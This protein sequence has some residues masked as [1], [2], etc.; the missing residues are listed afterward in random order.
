[1]NA[2]IHTWNEALSYKIFFSF[3]TQSVNEKCKILRIFQALS[4]S[5]RLNR[6]HDVVE[7]VKEA[8]NMHS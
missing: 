7:R 5:S 1:M 6:L 3:L 2:Y 4:L 8:Y